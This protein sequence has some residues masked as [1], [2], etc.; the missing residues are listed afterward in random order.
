MES[1]E[2]RSGRNESINPEA[3]GNF[4]DIFL[5]PSRCFEGI[6]IKPKFVIPLIICVLMSFATG[7]VIYNKIDMAQA[8]REQIE[9]SSAASRMSE[10]DIDNAVQMALK[11][12][13]I[14]TLVFGPL[15][16]LWLILQIAG[17][18]ILGLFISG[19]YGLNQTVYQEQSIF[20]SQ[21]G[22]S[23]SLSSEIR[24]DCP[25]CGASWGNEQIAEGGMSTSAK[26][27]SP[28]SKFIAVAKRCL[29]VSS[30]SMLFY[31]VVSGILTISVILAVSDPNTIDLRNPVF[32][33]PSGLVDPKESK[34]LYSFLSH[35]DILVWYTIYLMGL[36]LSK[37]SVKCSV[38][39]GIMIIGFWY[40]LYSLA[41]TGLSA[42]F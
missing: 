6:N 4:W 33:N 13:K 26:S 32:T 38:T 36:G 41:Q 19:S 5:E 30:I 39:K 1:N 23:I 37:V 18:M 20:C 3:G 24:Q 22:H 9:L 34:V 10:E 27:N 16:V 14:S 15:F 31:A 2:I 40:V 8:A 7:F 42:I 11:L 25:N 12:G 28:V 21:C 29:A 17:H 35:I